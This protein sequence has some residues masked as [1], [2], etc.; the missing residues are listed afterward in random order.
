MGA[1]VSAASPEY[2]LSRLLERHQLGDDF[3]DVRVDD[4]WVFVAGT[5]CVSVMFNDDVGSV[6]V[7]ASQAFW[8]VRHAKKR[9]SDENAPRREVIT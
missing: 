8:I 2:R 3:P 4:T 6:Q 9:R 1:E 5:C 7:S